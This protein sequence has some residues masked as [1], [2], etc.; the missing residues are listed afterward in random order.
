MTAMA[1]AA[2][3]EMRD[4]TPEMYSIANAIEAKEKA[5]LKHFDVSGFCGL[6]YIAMI[7]AALNSQPVHSSSELEHG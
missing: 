5:H 1:R 3:K 2:I 7:D 6:A 4:P